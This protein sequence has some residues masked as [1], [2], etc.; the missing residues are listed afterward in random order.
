M[1]GICGTCGM[2]DKDILG[3]MCWRNKIGNQEISEAGE[4]RVKV[5]FSLE[6]N[7]RKTVGLYQYVFKKSLS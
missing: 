1:C 7:V 6:T 4:K 5:K 2:V 3:R